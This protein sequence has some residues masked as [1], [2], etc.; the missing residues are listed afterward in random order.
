VEFA[1]VKRKKERGVSNAEFYE[2]V[3]QEVLNSEQT[4]IVTVDSDGQVGTFLT[5]DNRESAVGMIEIAKHLI[6][7]DITSYD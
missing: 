5:S 2:G 6:I 7:N 4:V 1:E 3:K